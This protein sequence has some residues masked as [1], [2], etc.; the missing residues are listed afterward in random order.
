MA[1]FE[2]IFRRKNDNAWVETDRAERRK[3]VLLT[4]L[5]AGA[6]LAGVGLLIYALVEHGH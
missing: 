3:V 5:W 2:R 1:V 6:L 4:L